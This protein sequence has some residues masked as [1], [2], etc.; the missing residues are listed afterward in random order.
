M[1]AGKHVFIEKPL[2]LSLDDLTELIRA[3]RESGRALS[4]GHNRRFSPH[5]R[6]L[7]DWRRKLGGPLQMIYTVNAE[8]LPGAHWIN[9]PA[10]GGG[11]LLG[12]G[13][14]FLDLLCQIAGARP[15]ALYAQGVLRPGVDPALC[16][17]FSVSLNFADNSIGRL[18]YVSQGIKE[19]PKERIEVFAQGQACLVY[20]FKRTQ[21]LGTQRKE[22]RTRAQ[23]KGQRPQFDDWIAYLGGKPADPLLLPDAAL[24]TYLALCAAQSL[25]QDKAEQLDF[26]RFCE[27]AAA[28]T[29][30][31][32]TESE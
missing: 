30:A 22:L 1:R 5:I 9:D 28:D 26:D 4:V 13:C 18:D 3:S 11:R 7:L 17:D 29:K 25:A 10:I 16:Q 20:D 31:E 27:Q 21:F 12:E 32:S 24:G 23:D 14:H 2:A 6:E 19:L 8:A 15:T